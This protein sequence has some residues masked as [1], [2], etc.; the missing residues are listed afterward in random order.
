MEA[1]GNKEILCFAG[2][3]GSYAIEIPYV[4]EICT[5]LIVSKFPCLPPH[6][7]G[8]C[9]YKGSIVPVVHI[10]KSGSGGYPAVIIVKNDK[11]MLGVQVGTEPYIVSSS[12]T[13]SVDMPEDRVIS[14]II[15]VKEFL[16]TKKELITVI[17]MEKTL[18]MMVVNKA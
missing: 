14:G 10:G 7:R 5:N 12:D 2:D 15:E 9:N 6:F 17:N 13:E 11:Y 4:T 1:K 16:K 18:E 3:N 8:V